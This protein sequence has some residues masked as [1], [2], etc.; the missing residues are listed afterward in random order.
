MFSFGK[1]NTGRGRSKRENIG[2]PDGGNRP[3]VVFPR[4]RPVLCRKSLP[5]APVAAGVWEVSPRI[6]GYVR[7]GE[8]WTQGI[9]TASAPSA[10]PGAAECI[11]AGKSPDCRTYR[12]GGQVLPL[13]ERDALGRDC[14]I[15]SCLPYEG[16][17]IQ[18]KS[19]EGAFCRSAFSFGP[20]TARLSPPKSRRKRWLAPTRACGRS[21][22]GRGQKKMGGASF[23][24]PLDNPS[25]IGYNPSRTQRG[26]GAVPATMLQ[27]EPLVGEKG[28]ADGGEYT[29][30]LA[31]QRPSAQ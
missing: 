18:V 27:R 8:P 9:R 30:E 23:G 28:R 5:G 22:F 25:F 15:P 7:K 19:P 21:L 31:P 20:C 13:P 17:R 12:C 10:S 1:E 11:P 6:W 29:L 3:A 24:G 2:Q 4:N 16:P 14:R 26:R